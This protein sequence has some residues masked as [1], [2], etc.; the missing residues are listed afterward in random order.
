VIEQRRLAGAEEAT[1]EG[2]GNRRR[3]LVCRHGF[4][5]VRSPRFT[6]P[7]LSHEWPCR[8]RPCP[9]PWNP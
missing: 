3:L 5:L 7:W 1:D 4:L 8:G 6:P 9:P 2:D